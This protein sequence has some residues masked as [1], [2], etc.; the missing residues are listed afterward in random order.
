MDRSP[1]WIAQRH[2]QDWRDEE[3]LAAIDWL[4]KSQDPRSWQMRI[5]NVRDTFYD[6]RRRWLDGDRVPLFDPRDLVAWYVFQANAYAADRRDWYEPEAFRL[7]PVFQRIGQ[8][9]PELSDIVGA[10][11]RAERILIDGRRQPDDGIY[12]LL[13]AGAYRRNGWDKVEFVPEEKGGRKTNDLFAASG[14][15]R[16]A[17]ECK[18]VGPSDYGRRERDDGLRLSAPV[19]ALSAELRKSWIVSVDFRIE[20]S[21]VPEEYLRQRIEERAN[22]TSCSW[23]DEI[24]QGEVCEVAWHNL[25]PVLAR[26]DLYFGSSRMIELAAGHFPSRADHSME[27]D[28]VS[29]V[30]RPFHA[31]NVT[32]LS[33][34]SWISSSSEAVRR[35]AKHFRGMVGQAS[36]QLPGDRPGVVHVGYELIGG[37]GADALRDMSN[38]FELMTFDP[39][40]SRLRWVYGNYMVPEHTTH[41]MESA[42]LTE[43]TAV[44]KVGRSNTPD[45]IPQH[46]LFSE[47]SA[48]P[49]GYWMHQI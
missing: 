12:E 38:R 31:H 23:D 24:A 10:Q 13:V 6:A 8:L 36:E 44:Y 3:T 20:L 26:D 28:W 27:G 42:A 33:L 25:Q 35:K 49:G 11:E 48:R 45:P 47:G 9:L 19:H 16:W 17:I 32:R 7:A 21:E 40:N 41:P 43:T 14:R 37:N 18:R 29:S 4:T 15:R 22:G 5:E 34:V 1:L 46:F 30:E 39:S 2:G